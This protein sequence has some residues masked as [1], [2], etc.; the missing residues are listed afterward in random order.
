MRQA[1]AYAET[2]LVTHSEQHQEDRR[3]IIQHMAL[4]CKT[5][6]QNEHSHSMALHHQGVQN[7]ENEV[8][9]QFAAYQIREQEL[10]QFECQQVL[11][12]ANSKIAAEQ[13]QCQLESKWAQDYVSHEHHEFQVQVAKVDF[14]ATNGSNE[15]EQKLQYIENE[16]CEWEEYAYSE[17]ANE[18]YAWQEYEIEEDA[19][20]AQAQIVEQASEWCEEFKEEQLIA[21]AGDQNALQGEFRAELYE[22]SI[23][24]TNMQNEL[25]AERV[26]CEARVATLTDKA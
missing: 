20:R 5:E 18:A 21:V 24:F 6:Y 4:V 13:T 22:Q 17:Q 16:E 19:F 25:H 14:L 10:M 15:L 9:T 23:Q 1:L 8:K 2:K 11:A 26:R 3:A 7:F 12:E